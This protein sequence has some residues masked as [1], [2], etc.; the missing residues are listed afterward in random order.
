MIGSFVSVRRSSF[1]FSDLCLGWEKAG[2]C[3]Y[4]TEEAQ[5]CHLVVLLMMNFG[6]ALITTFGAQSSHDLDEHWQL[7]GRQK[8]KLVRNESML[9]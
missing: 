3:T 7:A 9:L 4:I 8:S 5:I 6:R 1:E 2:I